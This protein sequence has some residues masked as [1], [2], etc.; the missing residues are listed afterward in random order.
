MSFSTASDFGERGAD[1]RGQGLKCSKVSPPQEISQDWPKHT[2]G[3][4]RLD[5]S[6][7]RES[8]TDKLIAEL[9]HR[10]RD[11]LV[12]DEKEVPWFPRHISEL[13]LIAPRIKD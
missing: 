5:C 3:A 9:K 2:L 13:D 10:C 12:L 8:N 7:S 1:F 4:T 6:L 11:M